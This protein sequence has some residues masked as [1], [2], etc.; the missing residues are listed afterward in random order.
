MLSLEELLTIHSTLLTHLRDT[1]PDYIV[2]E[3][4]D[5][6]FQRETR[7]LLESPEFCRSIDH[8]FFAATGGMSAECG[9]RHLRQYGLPLRA[10]AGLLTQSQLAMREAEEST[11]LPCLSIDRMMNGEALELLRAG[12]AQQ[13]KQL[14]RA[15]RAGVPPLFAQPQVA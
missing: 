15:S 14:P 1:K 11:S 6:I 2:I 9:V 10:T 8:M 3:V 5:G 4:A 7:M 13:T 12:R